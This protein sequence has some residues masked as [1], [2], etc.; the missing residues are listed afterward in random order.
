MNGSLA[1]ILFLQSHKE[2][3]NYSDELYLTFQTERTFLNEKML[4][5]WNT[6]VISV[7]LSPHRLQPDIYLNHLIWKS[8]SIILD[9]KYFVYYLHFSSTKVFQKVS[10]PHQVPH[11][12]PQII[13]ENFVT[14]WVVRVNIHKIIEICNRVWNHLTHLS[15]YR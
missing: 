2:V 14:R 10:L 13:E 1:S 15:L 11:T 7:T 5:W 3:T 8:S 9:F 12:V 6:S 4:G